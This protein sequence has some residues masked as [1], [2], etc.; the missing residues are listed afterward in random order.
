ASSTADGPLI[1]YVTGDGEVTVA[2]YAGS[3][4]KTAAVAKTESVPL[5][6]LST[7]VAQDE[8]GVRYVT[9]YDTTT[10]SVKLA[11]DTGA[12]FAP[13]STPE[14]SGGA[15]PSIVAAESGAWIAWYDHVNEN[16]QA[17]FYGE[18]DP[19]LAVSSPEAVAPAAP[20][21]SA[22]SAP[23]AP[24]EPAAPDG[25][26]GGGGA[27]A[28]TLAIE[29]PAGAVATGFDKTTLSAPANTPIQIQFKNSDPGVPHNVEIL[30]ADPLQDPSAESLF[31]GETFTGP[32]DATYDVPPLE[33]GKYFYRCIVHPT[34]MTGTLTVK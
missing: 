2:E 5:A 12:G 24:T 6:S 11:V 30:T 25:G 26:G 21:A 7:G 4:W 1:S 29:S 27:K 15:M 14:T 34:T 20:P 28:F 9:W 31:N 23:A 8:A 17:G 10:D 19:A 22:P 18:Q 16:L 32:A 3:T 13:V 33:P